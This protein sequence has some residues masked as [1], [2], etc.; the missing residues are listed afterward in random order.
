MKKVKRDYK[1]YGKDPFNEKLEPERKIISG[2]L[3]PVDFSIYSKSEYD[4]LRLKMA[5]SGI[6]LAPVNELAVSTPVKT[7]ATKKPLR[8]GIVRRRQKN[9]HAFLLS[10]GLKESEIRFNKNTGQ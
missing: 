7:A 2:D 4:K 6:D 9:L 1:N 3:E 5:K 10:R 8:P